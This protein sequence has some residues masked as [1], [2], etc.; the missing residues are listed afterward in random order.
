MLALALPALLATLAASHATPAAEEA[1]VEEA[2]VGPRDPA[3]EDL[4]ASLASLRR[5]RHQPRAAADLARLALLEEDAPDL[6]PLER[7]YGQ[8]AADPRALPEIRD[9]ARFGLA[10]LA[11]ARGPSSASAAW[12]RKLGLLSR[13]EV[14]GPFDGEG[15]RGFDAPFP[16]EERQDLAARY[17]GKVREVYWRPLPPEA[18]V[19]G[20]A[21]LGAALRPAREAVAYA[22]AMVELPREARV[23]L[24]A[25]ASGASKVWVNG[26]LVLSD[27]AYHPA[28]PGQQAALVT[29]RAGPNRILV[30]L[31][32]DE[33]R[34][35]FYL[36][37]TTPRGDPL[38]LAERPTRPL[39][40]LAAGAAPRPE[41]VAGVAELLAAR[42]GRARGA[43]EGRARLDL[44][45]VLADRAAS[46]VREQRPLA[47]ARRA[48]GLLPQSAEA[49]LTAARLE[50]D[51]NR[52]RARVE[53]ALAADGTDP[54]AL[55]ELG[56]L[57]LSRRR[58]PEAVVLLEKAVAAAPGDVRALSLL[59]DA[60]EACGLAARAD[61]LRLELGSRFPR[62]PA[63]QQ[64]AARAARRLDRLGDAVR[65]GRALLAL[66]HD[67]A[68]ARAA[69]VQALVDRGDVE[70]A[71]E[72]LAAAS[73]LD[74][75]DLGPRLRQGD[76]LAGSGRL[77]EAVAAYD[78]AERLSPEDPEPP[79]RRGRARLQAGSSREAVADLQRALELKPQSPELKELLRAVSPE[80]ERFER[81]YLYDAAALARAFDPGRGQG[82]DAVVLG[83][84]TATR[85][86]PSG[87]SSTYHQLVV[88]VLTRRGVEAFRR[89][90]I[91]YVPGRQE[92]KVDRVRVVKPD[93]AAVETWQEAE[94]SA[95]EPWY[96]L[97]YDTR[98][99]A[100]TFPALEPGDLL[101]LG[102]R[103]DDVAGENLLSD[104]FGDQV[105]LQDGTP[106]AR[107]DY[108]LLVPSSRR[109]H[110]N[111]PGVAGL[112]RAERALPGGVTEHRFTAR[113]LPR[114]EAEP[115]M[116]GP[117]EVV[118]FI[119][120]ST[121]A[122]WD[123]VARFY[124][125]LVRDQLRPTEELRATARRL[126]AE[127]RRARR[128]RGLPEAGDERAV[129]EAV[130]DFVVTGTRYVGLEF[131]IH[132]FKPYRVDQVLSRRFGDCKDKASLTH[133]LLEALGI[134]SRLVLLR[135][136]RLGRIPAAPASLAVFNHA[137]SY[138]PK[139]DL[140]L[141]GTASYSGSRELPSEDRGATVLVVNPDGPARFGQIPE[142]RPEENRT[143]LSL[144]AELRADGSAVLAGDSTVGGGRA[145]DYRRAYGTEGDR[146]ASFEQ[147][148][149][150]TFPG[151]EVK[152]VSASDLTRLDEDVALRFTLEVPHLGRPD[153]DGLSFSPFGEQS[154]YT[155]SYAPLSARRHPLVLGDPWENR[156]RYR[157]RLPA[158]WS[159]GALPPP[160]RL[161]TP[162]GSFEVSW[163][164]E[165]GS[166]RVEGRLVF[167]ATRVNAADY[168]AFRAFTAG[169][170][171]AMAR[172]VRV[173]PGATAAAS[174]RE[175]SHP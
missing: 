63:A 127:V 144:E 171:R 169:I 11:R 91:G 10:R 21:H 154:P 62:L 133:A 102:Y 84:L 85:V 76:L 117:S 125:G 9:L 2:E 150:R 39:P 56:A 23:R 86:Y 59:A 138:V 26:A 151:L 41:K 61:L 65:F 48:A 111:E 3:Q 68:L 113:D 45:L 53:A 160:S 170:D 16:P 90:S 32:H 116:P 6:T 121:Y 105:Y 103:V 135:M 83:D 134:D 165:G 18:V 152:T 139:Y 27:P 1:R 142:G 92:L 12:L 126:E 79:E 157:Y 57:E 52:R 110:V 173:G 163:R 167:R 58:G 159:A 95:S 104:Y 137:I 112:E 74:P 80:R 4:A 162:F 168:P 81:P 128:A 72:A 143:E 166:V 172:R 119:H 60:R 46:D 31:A 148:W 44:A 35:G 175:D 122:S 67:D 38:E 96:R 82:E 55:R 71:L 54:R 17:P 129:V 94:H 153:G 75:S 131:G 147:A 97:Y 99:R 108:V 118:P 88:K 109:L 13:F 130:H 98:T 73:R 70:G 37:F 66:R 20:F 140:W 33:G 124:W 87:L 50:D 42:A 30:K 22:L 101:E 161:D 145:P 114:L 132:G 51:S 36:G 49:Q 24:T 106:K 164:E 14:I 93:G 8:L 19:D 7:A 89:Q 146:R 40:P 78:A 123:D 141:D 174:K 43:E 136:N 15:K 69:L 149:S 29:L 28:R 5:D 25:G 156:F 64:A 100:L 77:A 34:M 107:V 155:E 158:G 47:E 115:G 120:V